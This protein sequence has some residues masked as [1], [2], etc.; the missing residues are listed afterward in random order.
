MPSLKHLHTFERVKIKK[1]V[2]RCIHPDCSHYTKKDYLRGKRAKC[3]CGNDFIV[4]AKALRLKHPHCDACSKILK[5]SKIEI[6]EQVLNSNPKQL[7]L[8]LP[9]FELSSIY[10][11]NIVNQSD[12]AG[13]DISNFTFSED[14]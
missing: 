8:S 3:I 6:I 11:E 7:P 4:T 2:Y 13:E 9:L 5:T 14:E 12:G 10:N 1:D